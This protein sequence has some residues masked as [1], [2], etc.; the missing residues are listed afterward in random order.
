MKIKVFSIAF[1][2][3]LFGVTKL[4][5]AQCC[6]AESIV[7]MMLQS[8]INAGY[9]IQ[10]YDAAG[11]NN[12]INVYNQKYASSLKSPL[13]TFGR[14][15]GP[16]FGIHVLQ[17]HLD[18]LLL[19]LRINYSQLKEKNSSSR[20]SILGA[21]I[22]EEF[23]LRLTSVGVGIVSSLI[24]GKRFDIKFLDAMVTW[25]T[26][27]LTNSYE[28]PLISTEQKLESVRSY[29]GFMGGAGFTFYF[30]PQ[31]LA[32]EATGGYSLFSI[33]EMQFDEGELLAE[34][35][36]GGAAMK[37]FINAGGWFAFV[38]LNLSVPIR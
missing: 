14:A 2:I 30:I 26:A 24:V 17:L 38:Q 37:N 33:S 7:S 6:T 16:K 10:V 19:S 1:L 21:N 15:I 4:T 34:R 5:S 8:G 3:L 36:D 12:Y 28:D 20:F 29:L 22:K 23:D 18:Q 25:N 27:K 9:G 32:L 11:F 35:P 13:S 31:Y